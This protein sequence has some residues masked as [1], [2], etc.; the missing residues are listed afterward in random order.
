M[1]NMTN[2]VCNVCNKRFQVET[3][4]LKRR[5][6]GCGS[7]CCQ[8]H[9][10]IWMKAH[11]N[12]IWFS[13]NHPKGHGHPHTKETRELL[14]K[15]LSGKKHSYLIERN[16]SQWMR[17]RVS[18]SKLGKPRS[19]TVKRHLSEAKIKQWRNPEYIASHQEQLK[20]LIA[21][22]AIHGINTRFKK[23]QQSHNKGKHLSEETKRKLK[24]R[25]WDNP[26][27][28]L[29]MYLHGKKWGA[30]NKGKKKSEAWRAKQSKR[31]TANRVFPYRFTKIELKLM[32]G[33]SDRD[34]AFY[35]T[36]SINNV[37]ATDISFPDQKIAIFCDGD[38]FHSGPQ[39]IN[40]NRPS[41]AM[42]ERIK[43]RDK[44][45]NSYL[46]SQGWTTLRYWGSE[47]EANSEAVCDEIEDVIFNKMR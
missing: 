15:K 8:A 20:K 26:D 34:Y 23:G 42:Q 4:A 2:R 7:F 43:K 25:Y 14:S 37:C 30:M 18:A 35:A 5:S 9:N 1:V 19:E 31:W 24:E 29:M 12:N 11:P 28:R 3:A 10:Y 21:S 41:N 36:M 32:N 38:Y 46:Q 17:E 45:V 16:K 27:R 44:Y 33:L 22:A 13:K 6:K 47:I 39:W 40:R